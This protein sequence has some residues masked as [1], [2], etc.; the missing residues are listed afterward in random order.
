VEKGLQILWVIHYLRKLRLWILT[1]RNW[2]ELHLH[3]IFF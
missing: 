2:I 1:W 3:Y